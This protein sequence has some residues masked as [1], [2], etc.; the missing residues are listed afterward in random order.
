MA[1]A[2]VGQVN[3]WDEQLAADASATSAA[4]PAVVGE[5]L[6]VQGG[7]LH[8]R[9]AAVPGN[10]LDV[11]ILDFLRENR[12]YPGIYDP[13]NITPPD[14]YAFGN[15]EKTRKPH[16]EAASP[17]ADACLACPMN[18]FGTSRTGKGKACGN[19]MRLALIPAGAASGALK[20]EDVAHYTVPVTSV[21]NFSAYAEDIAKT[22]KRPPYGVTTRLLV[23]PGGPNQYTV[24]FELVEVK[25]I[26]TDG[27]IEGQF[28]GPILEL[29]SKVNL[30]TPYQAA[31]EQ[32]ATPTRAAGNFTGARKLGRS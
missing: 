18:Q 15:D 27:K 1:R 26:S 17:Q 21:K 25:D 24:T 28:I 9:G 10:K 13:K 23:T 19:V 31:A 29:R 4:L 7:I 32:P 12:Y 30:A 5:S 8:F 20:L 22:L 16:Q 2:P 14:C 6:R 3:K 11:V